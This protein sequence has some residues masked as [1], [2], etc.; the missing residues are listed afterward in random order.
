VNGPTKNGVRIVTGGRLTRTTEKNP[1][2][3]FPISFSPTYG[4]LLTLRR[5]SDNSAAVPTKKATI[6]TLL[7]RAAPKDFNHRFSISVSW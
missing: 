1:S 2:A 6:E 5:G 4:W 3:V 7:R